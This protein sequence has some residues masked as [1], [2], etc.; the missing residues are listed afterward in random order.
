M[1]KNT[2][3]PLKKE[4]AVQEVIFSL[5]LAEQLSSDTIK[6]FFS[7]KDV[8]K[9]EFPHFEE[10]KQLVLQVTPS[11]PAANVLTNEAGG[12]PAGMRLVHTLENGALDWSIHVE[13]NMIVITCLDYKGWEKT[14]S[15]AQVYLQTLAEQIIGTSVIKA[16]NLQYT[17]IFLSSNP[18]HYDLWQV[19]NEKSPY[20]T[21]NIKKTGS[22]WHLFQGWLEENA[23]LN[24]RYLN[25][26]NLATLVKDKEH[27]TTITILRQAQIDNLVL[28]NLD[29][30]MNELH[31]DLKKILGNVLATRMAKEIGL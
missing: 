26:L 8:F 24:L 9:K 14:W 12:I 6:K 10:L 30:V 29:K 4:H 3:K 7:L 18:D 13:Q 21:D 22:L 15:K 31:D 5:Q 23:T 19:F 28:E 1:S 20:L 17:N 25:N 11:L 2:T 27:V 16:I